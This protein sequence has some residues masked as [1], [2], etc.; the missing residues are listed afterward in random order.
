[1]LDRARYAADGYLVVERMIDRGP[2]AQLRDE[3]FR[4]ASRQRGLAVDTQLIHRSALL[5]DFV[6]RG[7]QVRLAVELL[8]P[9]VCFTHQQY[10][11]KHPDRKARTDVPWHQ[12]SGYGR[13]EPPL[14]LTVWIALDDCTLDNGCLWVLP[15]SER[16]D[17]SRTT[18]SARCAVSSSTNPALRCRCDAGDAVLFGGL[19]LHRSLPNLTDTARVALYLRYC[20]PS[21][22]MV[23]EAPR[24][25]TGAR[26]RVLVDGGGRS[27]LNSVESADARQ[28]LAK[29]TVVERID[30]HLLA[31]RR[32]VHEAP[33]AE[34]DCRR[35]VGS[36]WYRRTA[37]R[38]LTLAQDRSAFAACCC[39]VELRGIV[40]PARWYA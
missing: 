27:A 7:P 9:N 16:V 6:T 30:R 18:A 32:R 1:M 10:I 19:L 36:S 40:S 34:I 21:V 8:G 39:A 23:G 3:A 14:D 25:Q 28:P 13:L 2:C 15:R 24:R 11:I 35:G 4:F 17:C 29:I 38:P 12:D 20:D 31:F 22:V 37:D 26:R 5:R 33:V